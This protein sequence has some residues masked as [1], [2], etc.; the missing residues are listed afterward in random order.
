MLNYLN[1]FFLF[2]LVLLCGCGTFK[3]TSRTALTDDFYTIKNKK[4]N[5]RVYVKKD[6]EVIM[7]FPTKP[8]ENKKADTSNLVG[9]YKEISLRGHK[10]IVLLRRNSF[11]I[12]FLTIPLKFRPMTSG[13]PAQLNTEINASAYFGL[14]TDRFTIEYEQNPSGIQERV[15]KHFGFS[16][17]GLTGIGSTLVSPTTTNDQTEQEYDGIVW[18]KGVAGI[19]ALNSVT[20]GISLGFDNLLDQNRSIWIYESKPWIGFTLGLNL[21]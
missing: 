7:I 8:N 10:D 11:D 14:R 15:V 16:F 13:V 3:T 17:G 9:V 2:F 6:E 20:I 18:T 4:R 21:N 19:F 5:E 12:D 1:V